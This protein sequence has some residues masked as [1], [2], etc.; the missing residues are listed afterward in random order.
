MNVLEMCLPCF[1][2]VKK[3]SVFMEVETNATATNELL[4]KQWKAPPVAGLQS[5]RLAHESPSLPRMVDSR[6]EH[7]C[8]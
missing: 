3:S 7:S 5:L 4:V 1:I 6:D 2:A 8:H